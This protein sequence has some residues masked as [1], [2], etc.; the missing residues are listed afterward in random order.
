MQHPIK[1]LPDFNF[2]YKKA[3]FSPPEDRD[4]NKPRRDSISHAPEAGICRDMHIKIHHVMNYAVHM[5]SRDIKNVIMLKEI[6]SIHRNFEITG[7]VNPHM[8]VIIGLGTGGLYAAR[9]ASRVNRK[10][11]ITIIEKR[12]YETY[13][14]C[15]IPQVIEGKLKPEDIIYPFPRT[16]RI[17]LHLGHEAIEVNT[18]EKKVLYRKVGE[19]EV[20]EIEY[21]KLIYA[22]G[23]IPKVPPIKGIKK[24]GVFTVRTVEDAIAILEWMKKSKKALVIGAGAIGVEMAYAL[25]TRGLKVTLVDILPHPFPLNLDEDLA[26]LVDERLRNEEIETIY[27]ARV[28]EITGDEFVDGAV[29]NGVRREY[30][31]VIVSTGVKPNTAMLEGKVEMDRGFIKVDE[32]MRTSD[33]DIFAIG[34]CVLTPYG[35]IQLATTAANQGIVAGIN[36]AGGYAVYK[37][38]TGAFVSVFGGFEVSAVGEKT[39]I[40]GRA[41]AKIHPHA[42]EEIVMKIYVDKEGYI[43]GAQAIGVQASTRINVISALIR[44]GA[45]ITDLAFMEHAYCPEVSELY[46]VMKIAAENSLRRFKFERYEV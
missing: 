40:Y 14:P 20:K 15:S 30:D 31:M 9:W 32:R 41:K 36:A 34:D 12:D 11:E 25:K 42:D 5:D 33:E 10:E 29:I 7:F 17:H 3:W 43:K 16:R 1:N 38:P 35:I 22:A 37:K 4:R 13:S 8:I 19:E 45:K 27:N 24:K 2:A 39:N 46:D 26:K 6:C 18:K 28:E 21:D 23:A 44:M